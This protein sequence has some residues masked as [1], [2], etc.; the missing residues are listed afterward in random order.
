MKLCI[1]L[2][3]KSLW[4]SKLLFC[5]GHCASHGTHE[6]SLVMLLGL[7][8]SFNRVISAILNSW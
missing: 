8:A 1:G 4:G 5:Q 3:G 6:V 2:L 7:V